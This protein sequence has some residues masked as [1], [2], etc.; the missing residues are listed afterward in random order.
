MLHACDAAETAGLYTMGPSPV[1]NE[2]V[3]PTPDEAGEPRDTPSIALVPLA[4]LLSL[5]VNRRRR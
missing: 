2:T 5:L 4:V 3:G 1:S